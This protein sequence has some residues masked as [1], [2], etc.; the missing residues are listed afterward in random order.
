MVADDI[1]THT[2]VL[3]TGSLL[4]MLGPLHVYILIKY[5]YAICYIFPLH[6]YSL[7]LNA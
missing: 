3:Y 2:G 6:N 7:F 4:P 1:R 5:S